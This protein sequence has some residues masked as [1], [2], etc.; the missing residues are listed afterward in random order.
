MKS[1]NKPTNHQYTIMSDPAQIQQLAQLLVAAQQSSKSKIGR[2]EWSG[3][4]WSHIRLRIRIRIRI[5]R[6][7]F[8]LAAVVLVFLFFAVTN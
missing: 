2:V 8:Y 7:F 1:T 4:E 5:R 6:V 3:M